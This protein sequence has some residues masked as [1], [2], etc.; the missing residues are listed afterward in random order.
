MNQGTHFKSVRVAREDMYRATR[1]YHH[2]IA[3]ALP[4]GRRISV[5][6]SGATFFA[7]V[8]HVCDDR[9]RIK[10]ERTGREYWIDIFD[11]TH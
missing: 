10:N 4:K 9:I 11:V 3:K 2:T 5:M 8:T 6:R 7:R 1:V